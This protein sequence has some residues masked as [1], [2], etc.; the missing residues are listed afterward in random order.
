MR[1][2]LTVTLL[3][4]ITGLCFASGPVSNQY[5]FRQGTAPK[6]QAIKLA[7]SKTSSEDDASSLTKDDFEHPHLIQQVIKKYPVN[8][9]QLFNRTVNLAIQDLSFKNYNSAG[10]TFNYNFIYHFLYPKHFFW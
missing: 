10:T 3:F 5:A 2:L 4:L 6:N 9:I 7:L 1:C 8:S